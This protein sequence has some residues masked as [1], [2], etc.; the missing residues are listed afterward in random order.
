MSHR[1]LAAVAGLGEAELDA[2]L[3]DAVEHHVLV[4][5]D[6]GGYAFRHALLGETVYDDLLPGERVRAHERYAAALADD[7]SLGTWAELAR[8]ADVRGAARTGA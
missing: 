7:R 8:H 5:T 4:P 3:R 6:S 2:G 1:L